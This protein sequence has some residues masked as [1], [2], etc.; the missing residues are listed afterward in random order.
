MN[1]QI[2]DIS[3]PLQADIAVWPGDTPF[4][5][6]SVLAR[7]KGASVNLTTITMSAHTG[8]HADAPHHFADNAAAIDEVAL[9][10][11][12][13]PAQVVTVSRA[14]GPLT[15]A[16]FAGCD[17]QLAPRLLVRTPAEHLPLAQF[18]QEIVYP[19]PDLAAYLQEQGII[20]Y[21]T[22][23]PSMDAIDSKDLPGHN[24]LLRHGIAILEG[25]DL[26]AA[27]DGL[28]ELVALPLRITGGDGSPVRAALRPL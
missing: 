17:L 25:L 10:P 2:I 3:R 22:D 4:S 16:D 1:K 9:A 6:E 13:G 20:L 8:S 11:Y 21:G 23:A 5:L 14:P 27:R 15:A 7:S 28:Y 12:W 26:N 24:A 18:P 19:T